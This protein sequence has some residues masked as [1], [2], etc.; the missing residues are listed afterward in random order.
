M[1]FEFASEFSRC[2]MPYARRRRRGFMMVM[3]NVTY[4]LS[5]DATCQRRERIHY[6]PQPLWVEHLAVMG[7]YLLLQSSLPSHLR[8]DLYQIGFCVLQQ[9]VNR[10][11]TRLER[12]PNIRRQIVR[13]PL[14]RWTRIRHDALT[15][16]RQ[17][18]RVCYMRISRAVQARQIIQHV[19]AILRF[20]RVV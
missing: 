15:I 11:G 1:Q 17:Y 3:A 12:R 5:N 7:P 19:I 18:G 10:R 2:A 14:L 9:H 13:L 6:L 4:L 16:R 8:I 20:P